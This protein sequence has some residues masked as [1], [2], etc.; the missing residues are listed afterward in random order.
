MGPA[1]LFKDPP[2]FTGNNFSSGYMAKFH[3]LLA[4]STRHK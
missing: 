1:A 4:N 2:G 3:S